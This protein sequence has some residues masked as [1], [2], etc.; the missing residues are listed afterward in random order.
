MTK[1][2]LITAVQKEVGED[3]SKVVIG[4][5]LDALVLVSTQTLKDGEAVPL[6]GL[7][8]FECVKRQ[9]RKGRN[10]RTGDV[11]DIPSS[12]AVKFSCSKTLKD[13]LN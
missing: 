11:I 5:V 4:N 12:N 7:G 13:A 2:D 1:A 3:V 10:P 8:K 6:T 9:A